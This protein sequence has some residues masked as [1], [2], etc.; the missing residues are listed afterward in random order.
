MGTLKCRTVSFATEQW[1][2]V[3][4]AHKQ[5]DEYE[6]AWRKKMVN[7]LLAVEQAPV[8]DEVAL[9]EQAYATDQERRLARLRAL[10][11]DAKYSSR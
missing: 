3:S 2:A 6:A 1:K 8:V 10:G 7:Q 5:A 4:I 9:A 11:G